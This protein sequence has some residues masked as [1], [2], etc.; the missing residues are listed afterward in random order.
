MAIVFVNVRRC[1]CVNVVHN[2]AFRACKICRFVF[3]MN[4]SE[5]C[6]CL[7]QSSFRDFVCRDSGNPRNKPLIFTGLQWQMSLVVPFASQ[8]SAAGGYLPTFEVDVS[9]ASVAFRGERWR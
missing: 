1:I 5:T 4:W 7:L 2:A 9:G 8:A 6:K 3:N